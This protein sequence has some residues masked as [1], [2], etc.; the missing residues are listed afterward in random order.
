MALGDMFLGER[1]EGEAQVN[2]R[3]ISL[4]SLA[5]NLQASNFDNSKVNSSIQQASSF[6]FSALFP[7]F[8]PGRPLYTFTPLTI[9]SFYSKS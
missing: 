9:T 1:R 8:R 3:Y 6:R 4:V 7:F 2:L 5:H